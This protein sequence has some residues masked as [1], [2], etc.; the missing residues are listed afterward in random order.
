[1][2]RRAPCSGGRR[3]GEFLAGAP[4]RCSKG[5]RGARLRLGC[6]PSSVRAVARPKDGRPSR[7]PTA[8]RPSPGG[9]RE[10]RPQSDRNPLMRRVRRR[11]LGRL[12][13]H[14]P[15]PS[16]PPPPCRATR[17]FEG[18]LTSSE[19][20]SSRHAIGLSAS[21]QSFSASKSARSPR[22]TSYW[23]AA[24]VRV[25]RS[26]TSRLQFAP[27]RDR[28]RSGRGP[29]SGRRPVSPP[30]VIL[31]GVRRP[32]PADRRGPPRVVELPVIDERLLWPVQRL[33]VSRRY[34]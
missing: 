26:S 31:L 19:R 24:S 25:L 17:A 15:R 12:S 1:M 2:T 33:Q 5:S 11:T 3:A 16:R 30:G 29:W 10:G 14:R 32:R 21:G 4:F 9:R 28:P 13:G 8:G 27:P 34:A 22:T 18:S 20:R 23:S 6:D 7:R